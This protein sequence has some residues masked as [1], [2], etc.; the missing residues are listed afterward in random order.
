MGGA[1][2]C[3]GFEREWWAMESK[4]EEREMGTGDGE[5][6]GGQWVECHMEESAGSLRTVALVESGL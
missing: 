4:L 2:K 3:G 1:W 6:V 5:K